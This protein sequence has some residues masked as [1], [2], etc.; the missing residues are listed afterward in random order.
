MNNGFSMQ[1]TE[2][3][4]PII[5]WRRLD[6]EY[7]L[8]VRSGKFT[9]VSTWLT[10]VFAC[11]GTAATLTPLSFAETPINDILFNRGIIPYFLVF[12]FAWSTSIL[13]LKWQKL[14]T[15]KRVVEFELIPRDPNFV[16]SSD[17]SQWILERMRYFTDEPERFV[18]FRRIRTA[19]LSLQNLGRIYDVGEVLRSQA[20]ADE[21][22]LETTYS[23]LRGF[24]WGIPV[25]GFI[26]T[27]LG[28]SQ[29][30]GSFGDVLSSAKEIEAISNSLKS[31]TAGL[32]TAFDTTLLALLFAI[33]LHFATTYLRKQ[34][35]EFLDDCTEYC[36]ANIVDRMKIVQIQDFQ[37]N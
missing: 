2:S 13:L 25:F 27:V 4:Q 21:A 22:S 12:C 10:C 7:K 32:S 6:I 28:L 15:Q 24:L 23:L 35:E 1:D 29:A 18:L 16:V 31:V 8:G 30:I 17:T 37:E 33:T 26:G 34:E 5:S 20:D 14:R 3:D 36:Q 9:G 11:I 19:L